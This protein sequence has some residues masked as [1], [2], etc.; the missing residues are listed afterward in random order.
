MRLRKVFDIAYVT[1]RGAE[2]VALDQDRKS[3]SAKI[4]IEKNGKIQ[5]RKIRK[6]KSEN[7]KI[8]NRTTKT[9]QSFDPA[10]KFVTTRRSNRTCVSS[11]VLIECDL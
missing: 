1:G 8:Q 9:L 7:R 3:K 6:L 10:Q 2:P 5:N 4:E 11:Y